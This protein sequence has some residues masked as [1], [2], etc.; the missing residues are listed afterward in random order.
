[1]RRAFW[2]DGFVAPFPFIPSSLAFTWNWTRDGHGALV[3]AA[4]GLAKRSH[5]RRFGTNQIKRPTKL[6]TR[7]KT[8]LQTR[9]KTKLEK[10]KRKR[11]CHA[12]KLGQ[13]PQPFHSGWASSFLF[14][15]FPLLQTLASTLKTCSLSFHSP[16][17]NVFLFLFWVLLPPAQL[18]VDTKIREALRRPSVTSICYCTSMCPVSHATIECR[19]TLVFSWW[20]ANKSI[21]P[22]WKW[23]EKGINNRCL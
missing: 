14:S 3:M 11:N 8:R 17:F 10:E 7:L 19:E 4:K 13:Q 21:N 2:I 1:M 23:V 15:F 18:A 9:L 16:C 20:G 12:A 5:C 6:K 22:F